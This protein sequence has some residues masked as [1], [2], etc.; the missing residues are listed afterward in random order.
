MLRFVQRKQAR[1]P[2]LAHYNAN[3]NP[4]GVGEPGRHPPIIPMAARYQAHLGR[5]G[6]PAPLYN[7]QVREPQF[8]TQSQLQNITG[9]A[10][11]PPLPLPP[12]LLSNGQVRSPAPQ[13]PFGDNGESPGHL[14]ERPTPD[15]QQ[16]VMG[17]NHFQPLP[18]FAS[19]HALHNQPPVTAEAHRNY[20]PSQLLGEMD[21]HVGR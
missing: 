20:Q 8:Q 18:V 15:F 2:G 4:A 14:N 12:K 7:N 13:G 5:L 6:T 17:S 21:Q 16:T 11:H 9:F 3:P 10:A 19:N 1:V